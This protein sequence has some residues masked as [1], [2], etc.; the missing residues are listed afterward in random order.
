MSCP[1]SQQL[2]SGMAQDSH[3]RTL[4]YLEQIALHVA[5]SNPETM[6]CQF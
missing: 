4:T 2:R 6:L 3:R 5:G 1:S